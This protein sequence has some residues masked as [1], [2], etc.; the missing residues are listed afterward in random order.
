MLQEKID[1]FQTKKVSLTLILTITLCWGG[2]KAIAGDDTTKDNQPPASPGVKP[3]IPLDTADPIH[4]VW[5]RK[6]DDLSKGREPGNNYI[7]VA[8]R[9]YYPDEDTFKRMRKNEFR[10]HTM[11]EVEKHG[12]DDVLENVIKEANDGPE[13]LFISFDLDTIDP[14][15]AP[16]TPEPGSITPR[17]AIDR[18]LEKAR[19]NYN[20]MIEQEGGTK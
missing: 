19:P 1:V 18:E 7:Q 4:E 20:I 13:H 16:G 11:A 14:S 15:F 6:R 5:K 12:W 2:S 17:N 9:G 10:Y 3:V 8:L